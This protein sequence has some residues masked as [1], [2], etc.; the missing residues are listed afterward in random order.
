MRKIKVLEKLKDYKNVMIILAQFLSFIPSEQFKYINKTPKWID[1]IVLK[2]LYEYQINEIITWIS[3]SNK[4]I[5][6]FLLKRVIQ[7]YKYWIDAG[8]ELH[9][10]K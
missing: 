2:I 3:D 8:Q 4:N 7:K 10:I 1:K 9:L 5:I 6:D